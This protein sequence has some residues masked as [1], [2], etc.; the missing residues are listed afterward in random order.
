MSVGCG[1]WIARIISVI[2]NANTPSLKAPIRPRLGPSLLRTLIFFPLLNAFIKF[3][4]LDPLSIFLCPQRVPVVDSFSTHH[5]GFTF[6]GLPNFI[7]SKAAGKVQISALGPS[8]DPCRGILMEF[9]FAH[10]FKRSHHFFVLGSALLP[11]TL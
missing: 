10:L 9:F 4:A 8:I 11:K 7:A 5:T 3:W 2:A 1:M 6:R